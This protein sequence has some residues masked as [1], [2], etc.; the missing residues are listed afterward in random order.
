VESQATSLPQAVKEHLLEQQG[1]LMLVFSR[2][3]CV[4]FAI[5]N[6]EELAAEVRLRACVCVCASACVRL[7]AS[8]CARLRARVC[9]RA[10]V[11]M[12]MCAYRVCVRACVH[13][14][15]VGGSMG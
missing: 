3:T 12:R 10:G 6:L 4:S 14:S 1:G 2:V 11:W 13:A 9:V 5:R 7:R 8:A 15:W